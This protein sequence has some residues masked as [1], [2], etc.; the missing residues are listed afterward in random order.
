MA[1]QPGA[2]PL[3]P[4][5]Q[6]ADLSNALAFGQGGGSEGMGFADSMIGDFFGGGSYITGPSWSGIEFISP[7]SAGDR[8]F[9]FTEHSSPVPA[10]RVFATYNLFDNALSDANGNELDL[11]RYIFGL[12]RTFLQGNASLEFRI[13]FS[14]GANSEQFQDVGGPPNRNT[15]FGNISLTTKFLLAQDADWTYSSGLGVILPTADEA[16]LVTPTGM[17]V[18]IANE[19]YYLQ[20]F[21]AVQRRPNQNTWINFLTQLDFA[22]DGNTVTVTDQSGSQLSPPE[23]YNDQHLLFLDLSLGRWFRRANPQ[24]HRRLNGVAGIIELHYTTTLNDTDLVTAGLQDSDTGEPLD[25]LT[26]PANRRDVLNATLGI[27]FLLRSGSTLTLSGVAPLR[28]GADHLFDSEF[29]V[30][31]SRPR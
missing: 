10:D 2:Q 30:Q 18:E 5:G 11:N 6:D 24:S 1:D 9:K 21:F 17:E 12:E 27:R 3:D 7:I 13:P 22:A 25:T 29:S 20:P 26:D 19:A 16:L 31:Y 23:I 28:D 14:N 8:R 4:S 15:E